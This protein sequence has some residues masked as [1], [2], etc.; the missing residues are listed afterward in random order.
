M[1]FRLRRFR[2]GRGPFR[3]QAICVKGNRGRHPWSGHDPAAVTGALSLSVNE[4]VHPPPFAC[5]ISLSPPR[6]VQESE[7]PRGAKS[8]RANAPAA[9]QESGTARARYPYPFKI[10]NGSI[11]APAAAT[12]TAAGVRRRLGMTRA[13]IS[14]VADK[15]QE[16]LD[17]FDGSIAGQRC[18][19]V[20]RDNRTGKAC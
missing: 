12:A 13:L 20:S 17:R 9:R 8:G 5:P 18:G 6:L 4:K 19:S 3:C 2:D 1:G 10:M 14:G 7:R 11:G 16:L 15:A